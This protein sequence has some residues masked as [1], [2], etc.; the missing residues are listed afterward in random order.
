MPQIARLGK[1]SLPLPRRMLG[2]LRGFESTKILSYRK[3]KP[4]HPRSNPERGLLDYPRFCSCWYRDRD[5]LEI[6]TDCLDTL[7]SRL[8]QCYILKHGDSAESVHIRDI[9]RAKDGVIIHDWDFERYE[10]NCFCPLHPTNGAYVP[11]R[12]YLWMDYLILKEIR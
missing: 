6:A 1:E 9:L 5:P 2:P 10:E 7:A 11:R 4:G 12:H 8:P 3:Q